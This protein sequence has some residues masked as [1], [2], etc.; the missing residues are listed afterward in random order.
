MIVFL[1][2]LEVFYDIYVS[3]VNYPRLLV[4]L[5]VQSI[6]QWLPNQCCIWI[7]NAF[8]VSWMYLRFKQHAHCSARRNYSC[9]SLFVAKYLQCVFIVQVMVKDFLLILND[10]SDRINY[11]NLKVQLVAILMQCKALKALF[12]T[13]VEYTKKE[14][15]AFTWMPSLF[16]QLRHLY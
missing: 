4:I 5:S 10:I 1:L 11:L 8:Q 6:C 13:V 3:G 2:E 12:V 14:N 7:H 15:H 9:D 16:H